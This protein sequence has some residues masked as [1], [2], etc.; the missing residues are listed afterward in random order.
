MWCTDCL[1]TIKFKKIDKQLRH[2]MFL[3]M[4]DAKERQYLQLKKYMHTNQ[5]PHEYIFNRC[6]HLQHDLQVLEK[7]VR[8]RGTCLCEIADG[9]PRYMT[10][11]NVSCVNKMIAMYQKRIQSRYNNKD[12]IIKLAYEMLIR[13]RDAKFENSKDSSQL[14]KL[15]SC[16]LAC[17]VDVGILGLR[18]LAKR[19]LAT[20]D[21]YY[22]WELERI[23]WIGYYKHD[24]D[25]NEDNPCLIGALPKD[26][27]YYILSL[28]KR[29]K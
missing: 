21:L 17:E 28:I 24:C 10:I 25:N 18:T 13:D 4:L 19:A 14:K 27:V 5:D 8:D 3:A 12:G 7:Y 20:L 29:N 9:L 1:K 11:N 2:E 23:V 15:F 6:M 22:P 16:E 26:I